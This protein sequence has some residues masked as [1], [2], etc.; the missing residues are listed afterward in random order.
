MA[1]DSTFPVGIVAFS[2]PYCI[3]NGYLQAH[4]L[5]RFQRFDQTHLS[6]T[7]FV[8]GMLLTISG[9][10]IGVQSDQILL[11]LRRASHLYQIPVGGMF[12]YVSCPHYFGEIL[13]WSGFCIACNGSLASCSFVIWTAANL[14]PRALSTHTWYLE[15]FDD[16]PLNRKAIVPFIL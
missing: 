9:F 10:T 3:V 4:D 8:L 12:E 14:V 5:C 15:K 16:Y 2:L 1:S 11:E 7:Q 13:E 6:S